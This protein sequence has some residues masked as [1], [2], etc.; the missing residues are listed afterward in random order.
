MQA[1]NEDL[2]KRCGDCC[3]PKFLFKGDIVQLRRLSCKY[4]ASN[5]LCSIYESR[6]K[7]VGCFYPH[8]PEV[9]GYMPEGCGYGGKIRT[10][11]DEEE[12]EF[13]KDPVNPFFI[14]VLLSGMFNWRE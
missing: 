7:E 9:R 11:S 14:G 1:L 4:L 3:T 5:N 8:E 6:K 12:K 13:L 10:L 2:C